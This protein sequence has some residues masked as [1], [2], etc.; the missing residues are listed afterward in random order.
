MLIKIRLNKFKIQ[1]E[2][3]VWYNTNFSMIKNF[4]LLLFFISSKNDDEST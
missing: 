1:I 3:I 4:R 2:I